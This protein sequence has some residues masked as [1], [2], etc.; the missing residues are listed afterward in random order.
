MVGI[1]SLLMLLWVVE[2]KIN[3]YCIFSN[4]N[5]GLGKVFCFGVNN[6]EVFNCLVW[7][8]DEL[9]LVMKVVIV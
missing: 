2:N 5:E 9:V 7:M 4:F 6:D 3:G 1:I 8:C